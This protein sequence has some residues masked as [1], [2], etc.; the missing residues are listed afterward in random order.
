MIPNSENEKF[1]GLSQDVILI[2]EFEYIAQVAFQANEDRAR[3]TNFYLVTLG[4]FIAA[5][6]SRGLLLSRTSNTSAIN[7]AFGF[8]CLLLTFQGIINTSPVSAI[9]TCLVRECESHESG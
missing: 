8:L 3:L 4:S 2:A 1:D 9:A 7:F 5:I 6:V